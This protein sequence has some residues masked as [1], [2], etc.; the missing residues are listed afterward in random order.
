MEMEMGGV[1]LYL[2]LPL[3]PEPYPKCG[4]TIAWIGLVWGFSNMYYLFKK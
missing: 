2:P 4:L 1:L 3:I